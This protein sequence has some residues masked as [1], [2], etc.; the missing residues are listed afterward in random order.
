MNYILTLND[1]RHFQRASE[2]CFVT[3][4]TLS[5]QIKKAEEDLGYLI[6]DRSTNPLALTNF[7]A[8]LIPIIREITND[9]SKIEV[10][11][12]TMKGSFI[13]KIRLGIIPTIASFLVSDLF[14]IWKDL[15]PNAQV[16]I[17]ELKT[18]DLLIALEK[19]E[20]DLGI[21]AGPVTENHLRTIPLFREEI[22]AYIPS[23][24][25]L[26]ITTDE[27]AENHPWLLSKGNCLRTQMVHFC[28]IQNETKESW[29]YEGGNLELL[30]RMVNENGGYTLIPR[31]V[32]RLLNMDA[33]NSKRI[34]SSINKEIPAREIIAVSPNK[35]SKWESI[36]KIIRSCQLRYNSENNKN[37]KILS[38][39]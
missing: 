31:E 3:Q 34:I 4:P 26:E 10:L 28:G 24:K 11:T 1:T 18:E 36:E 17:Q 12:Q 32:E 8:E 37:L 9:I 29:N 20:L 13:E 25:G 38:W 21:L 6:F 14:K 15:L 19:K 27:L 39:K 35:T 23:Y 30:I 16:I 2:L 7:G 33:T 22:K 5:M